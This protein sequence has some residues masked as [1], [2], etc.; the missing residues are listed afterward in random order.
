[1]TDTRCLVCGKDC[2]DFPDL[3][4]Y[5]GGTKVACGM[6]CYNDYLVGIY[7]DSEDDAEPM[8]RRKP[9]VPWSARGHD[10]TRTYKREK[11]LDA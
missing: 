1:M 5:I 7:M 8:I 4:V 3:V 6:A 2:S 9:R 11:D 10:K